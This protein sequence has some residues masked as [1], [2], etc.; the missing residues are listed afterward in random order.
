M[1]YVTLMDDQNPNNSEEV[2]YMYREWN[3]VINKGKKSTS[4]RAATN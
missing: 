3:K 1:K 4:R 2:E